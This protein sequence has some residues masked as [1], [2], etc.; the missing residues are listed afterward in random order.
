MG[1]FYTKYT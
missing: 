1:I